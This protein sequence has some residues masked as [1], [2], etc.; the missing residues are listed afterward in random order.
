VLA[1]ERT[2]AEPRRLQGAILAVLGDAF[3]ARWREALE[4]YYAEH[5]DL[6][7]TAIPWGERPARIAAL[8]ATLR[9]LEIQEEKSILKAASYGIRIDRRE[10]MDVAVLFDPAV[11]EETTP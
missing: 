10:D 8:E 4:G 6:E 3:M 5:P 11:L 1:A 2:R 9:A 7:R